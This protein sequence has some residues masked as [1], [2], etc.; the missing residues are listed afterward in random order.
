MNVVLV[1]VQLP[2]CNIDANFMTHHHTYFF[3]SG[4]PR[5]TFFYMLNKSNTK[6]KTKKNNKFGN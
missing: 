4:E 3:K 5:C 1:W 6:S 2:V